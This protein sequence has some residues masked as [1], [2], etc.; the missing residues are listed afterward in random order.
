MRA[1]GGLAPGLQTH[2]TTQWLAQMLKAAECMR[3][4]GIP[5]FPDPVVDTHG[6]LQ[7][8]D[9]LLKSLPAAVSQAAELAC[10]S[11]INAAQASVA[12]GPGKRWTRMS[13]FGM[14]LTFFYSERWFHDCTAPRKKSAGVRPL[15]L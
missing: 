14:V 6:N 11:K 3:G 12:P 9:Q 7:Y 2:P 4:H 8:D 13:G 15:S 10:R 5:N 1:S